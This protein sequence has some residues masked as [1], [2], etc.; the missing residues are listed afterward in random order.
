M[1]RKRLLLTTI[2]LTLVILLIGCGTNDVLENQ[3][4]TD[5]QEDNSTINASMEVPEEE[6]EYTDVLSEDLEFN[7]GDNNG[8][9]TL[10]LSINTSYLPADVNV[11]INDE[12][13][14]ESIVIRMPC[15]IRIILLESQ[16]NIE[17]AIYRQAGF[18][19]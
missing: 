1:I 18:V 3:Q 19:L 7:M 12:I 4:E 5:N 14:N 6:Q 17:R 15:G 16:V 2:A 11:Y 13:L 8:Q 9:N 10:E